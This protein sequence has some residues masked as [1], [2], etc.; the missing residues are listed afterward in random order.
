MKQN[1]QINQTNPKQNPHSNQRKPIQTHPKKKKTHRMPEPL[2]FR[3]SRKREIDRIKRRKSVERDKP[4]CEKKQEEK[5][6]KESV[7][8]SRWWREHE[9]GGLAR[10][11]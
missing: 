6:G 7:T 2:W 11:F 10:D 9:H 3:F 5:L 1:P 4:C 8:E